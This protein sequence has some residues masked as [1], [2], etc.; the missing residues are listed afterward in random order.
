MDTERNNPWVEQLLKWHSHEMGG[1]R[2]PFD[3][4]TGNPLR[5]ADGKRVTIPTSAVKHVCAWADD[6]GRGS[7]EIGW[8]FLVG[9]PGNGKSECVQT[10]C[11]ALDTALACDGELTAVLKTKFGAQPLPDDQIVVNPEDLPERYRADFGQKVGRLVLIQDAS[12]SRSPGRD[13]AEVLLELLKE[14]TAQDSHSRSIL[15]CCANRGVLA[16]ASRYGRQDAY[17][18][19][20][21]PQLINAIL[22]ATG[23]GNTSLGSE[24]ESCWPLESQRLASGQI[25]AACWPLDLE[26][27]LVDDSGEAS[28]DAPGADILRKAVLPSRW[29][30]TLECQACTVSESCPFLRNAMWLQDETTAA[31]LRGILRHA[32]LGMG[33]RWSFRDLLTLAPELIVGEWEDFGGQHPCRW[34]HEQAKDMVDTSSPT[35][36]Q[37]CYQLLLHLYPHALFPTDWLSERALLLCRNPGTAA[38]ETVTGLLRALIEQRELRQS[39]YMRSLLRGQLTPLLDPYLSS[40]HEDS[41]VMSQLEDAF[42]QSIA[43]GR[44]YWHASRKPVD[45]GEP[46]TPDGVVPPSPIEEK[47]ESFLEDAELGLADSSQIP[48]TVSR[49]VCSLLRQMAC[50]AA[51]RS[52]GTRTGQYAQKSDFILYQKTIRNEE[53]LEG[54]RDLLIRQMGLHD[55][56]FDALE[57][58]GQTSSSRPSQA[59]LRSSRLGCTIRPAPLSH[60]KR[61]GHDLPSLLVNGTSI[62]VTFEFNKT[63]RLLVHGCEA[64]TLPSSV[65]ALLDR[66]KQTHAGQICHKDSDFQ[67]GV[68]VYEIGSA[69][70]SIGIDAQGKPRLRVPFNRGNI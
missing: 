4:R 60:P 2:H 45:S 18:Q 17:R 3:S 56:E 20:S 65:R 25:S 5:D 64:G 46:G 23:L 59:V 63:L 27:L 34:V 26:S 9:G 7:T 53:L 48:E 15:L 16:R 31:D 62:P 35:R 14:Q 24:P 69:S 55:F 43:L 21:V 8:V 36:A 70:H 38:S 57:I 32:E 66:A 44:K 68:V 19:S 22:V 42:S 33:K 52:V 41:D 29:Q 54:L 67:S 39:T 51:K 10:F 6:I 58:L 30:E 61:P 40:P 11:E 50:M 13:P 1:V 49:A 47:W 28:F 12:A 37:A